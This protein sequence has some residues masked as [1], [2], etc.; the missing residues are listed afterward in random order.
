[1]NTDLYTER[2]CTR[3]AMPAQS[4]RILSAGYSVLSDS[5]RLSILHARLN[6]FLASLGKVRV[7]VLDALHDGATIAGTK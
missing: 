7:V 3:Y 2:E 6:R 1:M 4:S 5:V